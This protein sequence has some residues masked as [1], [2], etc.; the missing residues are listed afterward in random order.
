MTP[1]RHISILICN[2]H[3]CIYNSYAGE[4]TVSEVVDAPTIYGCIDHLDIY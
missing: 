2:K 1:Y 3:K 4:P